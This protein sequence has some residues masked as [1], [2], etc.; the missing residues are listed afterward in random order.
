MPAKDKNAL[1]EKGEEWAVKLLRKNRYR[2]L[3]RNYRCPLGE[4]DIVAKEGDTL[5]FVEV[6]ARSSSDYGSPQAAVGPLKQR[7]LCQVALYY[8]VKN[9]IENTSMRFDVVA[10]DAD[11]QGEIIK[12]AFE[13]QEPRG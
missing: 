11:G 1:G 8:I 7:K 6:K 2:I 10:I 3:E 12:N 4:I 13:F 9:K 5:A